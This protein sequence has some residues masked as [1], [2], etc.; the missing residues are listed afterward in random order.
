[1][2]STGTDLIEKIPSLIEHYR[3]LRL[4]AVVAAT[5]VK[6]KVPEDKRP[7]ESLSFEVSPGGYL[8]I[9]FSD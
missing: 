1:V 4:R 7:G 9:S 5:S 3:P 2:E 6:G 8:D